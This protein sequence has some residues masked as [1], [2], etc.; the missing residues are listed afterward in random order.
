MSNHDDQ[1]TSF[2]IP[3]PNNEANNFSNICPELYPVINPHK[4]FLGPW[5]DLFGYLTP[6]KRGV[7]VHI[8]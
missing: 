7:S 1:M 2:I 5:V 6:S 8:N 4:A 3:T